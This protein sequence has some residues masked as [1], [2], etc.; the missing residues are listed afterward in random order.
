[1]TVHTD[2]QICYGVKFEEDYEFPWAAQDG[3]IEDWWR[4][5]NGYKPPFELF[6]ADGNYIDG[7][8]PSK[9]RLREYFDARSLWDAE[10]D[11]LPVAEVNYCSGEYP[12]YI[13]AVPS[14]CNSARRGYPEKFDPATLVVSEE[15]QAALLAFCEKYGLTYEAGPAWWLSSYWG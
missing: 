12:M 10:H 11:K 2:G 15:A 8:E 5:I 14:T 7:I 4:V 1:M 9:A 3:D 6:N 13:L